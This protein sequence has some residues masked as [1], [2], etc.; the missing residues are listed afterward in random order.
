MKQTVKFRDE[1]VQRAWDKATND[2]DCIES[3]ID[4]NGL[5]YTHYANGITSRC[6]RRQYIAEVRRASTG[7][8]HVEDLID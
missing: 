5:L 8:E 1:I 6:S 2:T 3:G 7:W 4:R